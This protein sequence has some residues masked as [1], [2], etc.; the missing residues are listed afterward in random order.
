[1]EST[2]NLDAI[3]RKVS[4][5]SSLNTGEEVEV[6]I[7]L[8]T[9]KAIEKNFWVR[10]GGNSQDYAVANER[11][12]MHVAEGKLPVYYIRDAA[13]ER[14]LAIQISLAG[15]VCSIGREVKLAE[16]LHGE[17]SPGAVFTALVQ[18]WVR[19]SIPPGTEGQF[20]DDY[21]STHKQLQNSINNRA[22]TETG[23]KLSAKVNLSGQHE[24][25][26]NPVLGP[27][28]IGVR[29][30][31]YTE[32]QKIVVEAGLALDSQTYVKAFIFQENQRSPEALFKDSLKE[33]FFTAV[34]Y[35]QFNRELSY[36]H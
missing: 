20:M 30:K 33:Y 25:V 12:P 31:G 6:T 5:Q 19:A 3:I 24:V 9:G 36:P 13:N 29:L 8:A 21:V 28:E 15:I 27:L 4:S 18:R 11:N 32:E 16:A 10:V 35:D 14:T 26:S 2:I 1:M 34:T 17:Q 7:D 22:L 23:L